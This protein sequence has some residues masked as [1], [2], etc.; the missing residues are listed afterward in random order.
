MVITVYLED[1]FILPRVSSKQCFKTELTLTE[2]LS[3]AQVEL[4]LNSKE[5]YIAKLFSDKSRLVSLG[6]QGY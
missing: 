3:A 6:W 5:F 4:S 2:P 1:S